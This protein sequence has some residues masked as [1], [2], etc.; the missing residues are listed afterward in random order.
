M[1]TIAFYLQVEKDYAS[2]YVK[3]DLLRSVYYRWQLHTDAQS[4][5]K[6]LPRR[7]FFE[8]IGSELLFPDDSLVEIRTQAEETLG[9]PLTVGDQ[10]LPGETGPR[11]RNLDREEQKADFDIWM[12]I[13]V[14]IL[15]ILISLLVY[16]M[17][18]GVAKIQNPP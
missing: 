16:I 17:Y 11:I 9:I 3:E 10:E 18:T 14:A 6:F 13:Y 1:I 12:P 7:V 4:R 5:E 15:S 8:P 2:V